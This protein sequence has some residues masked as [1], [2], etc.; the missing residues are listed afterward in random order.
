MKSTEFAQLSAFLE[1]AETGGFARAAARLAI[2]PSAV[3]QSIR[4]L[5]DRLGVRLFNRTTRSVSMT[6]AGR[7]LKS[8]LLPA[9]SALRDATQ[10]VEPLA[11]TV[12]GLVRLTASRVATELILQPRL[13]AFRLLYPE[14]SLE[15]SV[16][17]RSV[18]LVQARFDVGIRRGELVDKDM[19]GRRLTADE[20]MVV[21]GAASYFG[22]QGRPHR[23]EDLIH[24]ECIRIRRRASET[25]PPW[26]FRKKGAD[27]ELN[28]TGHVVVDDAVLAR[29]AAR[30]GIG[31]AHLARAFV[32]DD[33]AAGRLTSVLESWQT[34]RSGFFL[35]RSGRPHT[36]AAVL[37]L[38]KVLASPSS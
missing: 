16:E 4:R 27:F 25:L 13:P 10:V 33:L 24:H 28:V 21:V 1:V 11:G 20:P 22:R 19:I 12:R 17:D 3:S 15:I 34:R 35:Y 5:E 2:T 29:D 37:A 36:P 8:S 6:E 14:V 38:S 7:L 32:A 23:P 30:S 18:D 31:L 26:R 9:M